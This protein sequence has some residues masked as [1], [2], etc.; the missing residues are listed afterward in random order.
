[1]EALRATKSD[2]QSKTETNAKSLDEVRNLQRYIKSLKKTIE[3]LNQRFADNNGDEDGDG[4][5]GDVSGGRTFKVELWF[6]YTI[7]GQLLEFGYGRL[8]EIC[9]H[10]DIKTKARKVEKLIDLIVKHFENHDVYG[11]MDHFC[12][13]EEDDEE[14]E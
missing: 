12:F 8:K 11:D 2:L 4:S 3:D 1:M 5:N 9:D 7:T 13:D 10:L 6:G 14:D